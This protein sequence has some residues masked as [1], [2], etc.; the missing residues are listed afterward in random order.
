MR[1]HFHLEP[2]YHTVAK[3]KWGRP[4]VN[5]AT[6]ETRVITEFYDL[7]RPHALHKAIVRRARFLKGKGL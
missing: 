7:V 5:L 4:Q 2:Y 3:V 1:K 6:G